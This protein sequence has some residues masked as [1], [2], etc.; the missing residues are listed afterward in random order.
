MPPEAAWPHGWLDAGALAPGVRGV[1]TTR[2]GGASAPPFDSMNLRPDALGGDAVDDPAAIAANQRYLSEVMRATPVYLDQVHGSAVARLGPAEG[3]TDHHSPPTLPRADASVTATPG[4]ACTVLVAD[5]LPVL[6]ARGDGRVV[7]AAHAGWRGLAAGVLERTVEALREPVQGEG[8][9]WTG[10][11]H[12]WLGACIGP[13]A[14]EVGADVLEVF[15]ADGSPSA[16]GSSRFR[17][18]PRADGAS[19]W[20]ADLA[21][22]ALDRL[23][24]CGV[25]VPGGA[26][27]PCTVEDSSRFFSFRRDG[28]TGRMAAC[29]WIE[30]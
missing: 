24:A 3:A 19:R 9:G 15:G 27:P 29:I 21:G 10:A 1:M 28:R 6:F 12:A 14:F 7:G 5:C 17:F 4:I 23:Q 25:S 2:H 8:A 13:R 22:L 20:R 18:A 26:T 11:V 16:V 30:R